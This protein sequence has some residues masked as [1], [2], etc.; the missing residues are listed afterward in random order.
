[1][2]YIVTVDGTL[3]VEVEGWSVGGGRGGEGRVGEELGGERGWRG[4]WGK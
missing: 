1:M 4:E 3:V 2:A